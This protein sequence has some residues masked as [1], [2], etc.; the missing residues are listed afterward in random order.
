MTP[1]RNLLGAIFGIAFSFAMI[2]IVLTGAY[3]ALEAA[4]EL[5]R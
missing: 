2:L 4:W 5:A 1:V 3:T